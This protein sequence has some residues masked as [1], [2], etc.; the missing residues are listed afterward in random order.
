MGDPLEHY[1]PRE[2]DF[3]WI[4]IP[5]VEY[6]QALTTRPRNFEAA[7]RVA[8]AALRV[9][10]K[11]KAKVFVIENPKGK[12]RDRWFMQPLRKF[13]KNT[14]YCQYEDCDDK[15]FWSEDVVE[16]ERTHDY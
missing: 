11:L 8:L 6:S 5:C 7:D 15:I 1:K 9:A 4:S 16:C 2:L 13:L 3:L 10:F 14:S 12:L